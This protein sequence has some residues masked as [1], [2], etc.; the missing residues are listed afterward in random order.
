MIQLYRLSL[1]SEVG[2]RRA[3]TEWS[4]DLDGL[5]ANAL[6]YNRE[7]LRVERVTGAYETSEVTEAIWEQMQEDFG[8]E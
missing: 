7:H 2:E 3:V 5:L 1:V 4:D 8:G 6:H